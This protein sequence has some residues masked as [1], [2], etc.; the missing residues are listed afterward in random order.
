MDA[1]CDENA[2]MHVLAAMAGMMNDHTIKQFVFTLVLR[3][4]MR[5]LLSL[6]LI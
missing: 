5:V 6:Y 3:S 2:F 1:H 4:L